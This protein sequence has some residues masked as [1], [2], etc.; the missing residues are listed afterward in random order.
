MNKVADINTRLADE[1]EQRLRRIKLIE[2]ETAEFAP[3][4]Q[5]KQATLYPTA[6]PITQTPTLGQVITEEVQKNALNSD[7]LY[8]RAEQK[9]AQL[10]DKTN[11]EYILDRLEDGELFYLV[12]N[13]DGIIKELKEK[14]NSKSLDKNIF[15]ALVKKNAEDQNT[16]FQGININDL[17]AQGTLKKQQKEDKL[18]EIEDEINDQEAKDEAEKQRLG[19]L[20]KQQVADEAKEEIQ[21][22]QQRILERIQQKK[23]QDFVLKNKSKL[24]KKAPA[25]APTSATSQMPSL[26]M[27][28]DPFVYDPAQDKLT[29]QY[30][31]DFIDEYDAEE[32]AINMMDNDIREKVYEKIDNLFPN[33]MSS[34][35]GLS[36]KSKL[37]NFVRH[38]LLDKYF[39]MQNNA[40]ASSS[41]SS[42]SSSSNTPLSSRSASRSVSRSASPLS[43]TPSRTPSRPP[44]P[45]P[46]PAPP[47][48]QQE[49]ASK[50]LQ[51]FYRRKKASAPA[52]TPTSTTTAQTPTST[53]P[54][55]PFKLPLNDD[56]FIFNPNSDT[57]LAKYDA[58]LEADFLT[59]SKR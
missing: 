18:K 49:K 7:V 10:A 48:E 17:T 23:L 55:Q 59:E 27:N 22:R 40:P 5:A 16:Q 32:S 28:D 20:R 37:K 45:P 36:V 14:F 1:R 42:S 6:V 34:V 35:T 57:L 33:K 2:R 13:W 25:T 24:L 43:G 53:T 26:V 50:K 29:G 46:A 30:E 8:Q 52:Q 58:D 54:A 12:N 41:S 44:S 9:I 31:T 47:T 51:V 21:R 39:T 15:I 11:T 56:P 38:A 19:D 4:W 3:M